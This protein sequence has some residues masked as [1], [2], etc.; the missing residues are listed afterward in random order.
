M[1]SIEIGTKVQILVLKSIFGSKWD[2]LIRIK[3]GPKI[4]TKKLIFVLGTLSVSHSFEERRCESIF[5]V[6]NENQNYVN[7]PLINEYL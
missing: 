3:I 1:I 5:Y 7:S 2:T 4:Q 6:L